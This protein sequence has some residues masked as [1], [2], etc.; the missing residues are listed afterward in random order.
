MTTI[1]VQKNVLNES[2]LE[3]IKEYIFNC[4]GEYIDNSTKIN[5]VVDDNTIFTEAFS[6]ITESK[7]FELKDIQVFFLQKN[8]E[9]TFDYEKEFS[10]DGIIFDL[11]IIKHGV[12]RPLIGNT[13][14]YEK[15]YSNVI[16]KTCIMNTFKHNEMMNNRIDEDKARSF[17]QNYE[18]K[19]NA[20]NVEVFLLSLLDFL[21]IPYDLQ[22]FKLVTATLKICFS[23]AMKAISLI[24]TNCDYYKDIDNYLFTHDISPEMLMLHSFVIDAMVERLNSSSGYAYLQFALPNEPVLQNYIL[25]NNQCISYP[26]NLIHKRF[27]YERFTDDKII[28]ILFKC[29]KKKIS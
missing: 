12:R 2:T 22:D 19:E 23:S 1:N 29:V 16:L 8:R 13:S 27:Q 7:E 28:H 3:S 10:D 24:Q 25:Q 18:F 14:T 11:Q 5:I 15:D 20:Y 6:Q 21:K 26:G 4:Q 17:V 9:D